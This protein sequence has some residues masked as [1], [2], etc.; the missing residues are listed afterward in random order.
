V[1]TGGEGQYLKADVA[2][3]V[4]DIDEMAELG[5]HDVPAADHLPQRSLA[6]DRPEREWVAST[7]EHVLL[8]E[9]GLDE[10]L[11]LP[12][13]LFDQAGRGDSRIG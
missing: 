4:A 2:L 11:V 12:V 8:G 5:P 13:A 3:P 7:G 1:R 9:A 10:L 6:E